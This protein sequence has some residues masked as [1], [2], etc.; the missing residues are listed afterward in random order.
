VLEVAA[1][2]GI[3]TE[4]LRRSMPGAAITATDLNQGMVDF[5]QVRVPH[6]TWEQADVMQLPMPDGSFDAVASQFGAM[7][8]PDKPRAFAELRR[9]LTSGGH[10][11]L[12]V[13]DAV[14]GSPV[15]QVL[16]DSLSTIFPV[17]PPTF[18]VDVPHG[19]ADPEGIRADLTGGGLDTQSIERIVLTGRAPSTAGV[20]RGFCRGTPLRF[21]LEQRGALDELTEQ[22][23][24][25]MTRR[26]GAGPV[27]GELAAWLIH[28]KAPAGS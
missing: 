8:F 28:A 19:Y 18:V 26:L 27:E 24:A 13:W 15:T 3:A 5:A 17:D 6:V 12:L 2:T 14:G 10:V 1:G 21:A 25:E 11:V 23:A 20:A 16:V 7:F 9:V 22:V 4:A